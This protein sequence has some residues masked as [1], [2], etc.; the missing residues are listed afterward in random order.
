MIF[1]VRPHKKYIH[2]LHWE[3]LS[4]M[5]KQ[6]A[7]MLCRGLK[8]GILLHRELIKVFWFQ[9]TILKSQ[10]SMDFASSSSFSGVINNIP[11]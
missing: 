3:K 1:V 2:K 5:V 4:I 9:F 6:P 7:Y 10:I 11:D 8:N